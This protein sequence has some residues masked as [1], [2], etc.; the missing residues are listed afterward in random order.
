MEK[1]QKKWD[2]L[3]GFAIYLVVLGH[4]TTNPYIKNMIYVIHMPL[5][6]ITSGY[7]AYY[8][9]KN[10]TVIQVLKKK[11][12]TIM[13]PFITWSAVAVVMNCLKEF[14]INGVKFDFLWYK[15]Y[16]VYAVSMS[17]WFLW[18]LFWIFC[19]FSL[20]II[21][22]K[23]IGNIS[24]L[25]VWLAMCLILQTDLFSVCRLKINFIWFVLGYFLHFHNFENI[26]FTVVRKISIAYIPLYFIVFQLITTEEFYSWYNFQM[27][28]FYNDIEF[29][30]ILKGI[31]IVLI[32][33]IYTLIGIMFVWEWI[34]P[35]LS[36]IRLKNFLEKTGKLTLEIYTIHMM[37]VTY[38]VFIP[39][40]I[41][42]HE[43][44]C[45]FIYLPLYAAVICYIIVFLSQ[46]ILHKIKLYN[47]IML[48]KI[49][50]I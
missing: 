4:L 47:I 35:L 21:L 5:F 23:R 18:V 6:F 30:S 22:Q 9:Y 15:L 10:N 2:I 41:M 24:F 36:R 48:G 40:W 16:D 50:N 7:L 45:N 37:F 33:T 13:I 28:S 12:Y 34:I 14:L 44:L 3:K 29:F 11:F 38:I 42:N 49:N 27:T 25:V 19:L 43:L 26:F 32:S 20:A 31:M 46:K 39:V 1:R 17:I 8:S